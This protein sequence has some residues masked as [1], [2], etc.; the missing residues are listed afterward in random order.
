VHEAI[1]RLLKEAECDIGVSWDG[2][3]F[4][5]SGA[6]ELDLALVNEPLAWI[7]APQYES[8]RLPMV[9]ALQHYLESLQDPAKLSDVITDAYESLEAMGK[10]VTGRP[11]KDLSA[12]AELFVT[13]LASL[14]DTS[15][16]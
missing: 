1:V 12:N 16:S 6:L 11:N 15:A 7:D 2:K 10:I 3:S 4:R 14:T 8:V 5:P 9:K 13:R